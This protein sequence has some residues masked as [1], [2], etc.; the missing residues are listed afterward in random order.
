LVPANRWPSLSDV[1]QR[2]ESQHKRLEKIIS[3]LSEEQLE[4]RWASNLKRC[5]RSAILH[6]LHDE[7]CHCGE[8]HLLRKMQAAAKK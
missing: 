1:I 7:A 8:L 2:L 4:S 5:A 3:E 6:G